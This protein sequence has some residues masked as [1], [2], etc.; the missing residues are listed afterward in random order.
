MGHGHA[1]ARSVQM[2]QT[3]GPSMREWVLVLLVVLS[4][5]GLAYWA[6]RGRAGWPHASGRETASEFELDGSPVRS[7]PAPES[8]L[9]AARQI[10]LLEFEG[11]PGRVAVWRPEV[12]I[13][14]HSEDDIQVRDVRVSRH[15]ARLVARRDGR[16]EIHNLT[17]VRSEPNPMQVNGETREYADLGDGDVVTLGGVSFTLWLEAA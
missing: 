4:S 7:L 5:L 17:A 2:A 11:E 14:R 8:S 13:G 6:I 15:H 10:A 3:T 1:D 9:P 12:V 16:F